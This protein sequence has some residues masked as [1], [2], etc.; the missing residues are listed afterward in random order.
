ME[1]DCSFDEIANCR[2]MFELETRLMMET[3]SKH[4]CVVD[5]CVITSI[6]Y[7]V[8]VT[9]NSL[10]EKVPYGNITE[11]EMNDLHNL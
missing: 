3:V 1:V 7:N 2:H 8:F 4:F 10:S 9:L 11:I 6:R 5:Y